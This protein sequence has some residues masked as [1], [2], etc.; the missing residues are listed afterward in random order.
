MKQDRAARVRA[1]TARPVVLATDSADPSGVGHHMIALAAHLGPGWNP[2]LAFAAGPAAAGFL[3]RARASGLAAVDVPPDGWQGLLA[4]RPGVLHVHAGIGWEGSGPVAA[5]RAAGWTVVRTEHLPWLITEP[6]ERQAYAAML[7]RVDALIAVSSSA[8][9]SWEAGLARMSHG[10]PVSVIANGIA[11]LPARVGRRKTRMA[12]GLT[13]AMPLILNIGRFTPQKGHATLVAAFAAVVAAHPAARLMMVGSGATRTAMA[14]AVARDGLAGASFHDARDDVPDLMAAA[15]LLVL[16]SLFEGLPLVLLEAMAAGLPVVASRTGGITDALGHDYPYLVPPGA[17]GDLARAIIGRLDDPRG[18]RAT[19]LRQ[20]ARF[21][22]GF[23]AARMAV[24]TEAVYARARTAG[25]PERRVTAMKAVTDVGFIG[26]GGIAERHLGVLARMPDVRVVAV[27]DTD[28]AR[29]ADAAARHGAQAFDSAEAMIAG[30][31]LDAL[32]ICVPPFAHGPAER[33][34]LAAGLP[35]F[36]EKPITRDLGLA[37]ELAAEVAAAGIVTAVGYH[38]R[39]LDTVDRARRALRGRPPQLIVG[40]W[41]DSTPPP[42][43]WGREAQSGGQ[44]VEQVTHLIDTARFLAGGVD[45]VHAFGNHLPRRAWPEVDVATASVATLRFESGTVATF[46]ATCLLEWNHRSGLHLFAEGLAI[47]LSDR[48]VMI[49]VGAGRH[50]VAA[51]GDPVWREDRDFIDAV[52]GGVNR[53]R[54]GYADALETHRI[55][56][57]MTESIRSGEVVRLTPVAAVPLPPDAMLRIEPAARDQHRR[58]R[59]LGVEAP[60]RAGF[61]DYDE[62]PAGPGQVRLDTRF[63][64]LSAGTELTFFK[65]TNPYLSASWDADAGV[66]REGEAA[67]RFPVPF[68]GYMEVGRVIDAQAE[69]FRVGDLVAGSWAHKTGHTADA[70]RDLLVPLPEALD[71][72]LGVF[73]AQMGPIAANAILYADALAHGQVPV[74]FGAG[75][76]GRRVLVWGGGTVGLMT[77]LFARAAGAAEIVLAEPSAFRRQAAAR[78]GLAAEPEE[79]AWQRAKGWGAPGARGADIVFQTRAHAGSLHLALRALRPQGTVIDLAFYQ[80]GMADLRLGE[81]FHHNGLGLIVAQIGRVPAGLAEAWTRAR[82]S[83]QTLAL[84]A[85]EGPAIRD[86]MITH[87]V[88][89]DEGPAFLEHLVADRPEFLQI[90]FEVPT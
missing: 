14:E 3:R 2:L 6:G 23:T 17:A 30:A 58:I 41:L 69:G 79:A 61:F 45:S 8:G 36:V 20:R 66:F 72:V 84:L 21:E 27:A 47:E 10:L 53:I 5:G 63:T 38:W 55:A 57:A 51:D 67:M 83:A 82:L 86:A 26:A 40:H 13:D 74:A 16:P 73:V 89:F 19:A 81:E 60:G 68:L 76:A 59:S 9:R 43:W 18:A 85:T 39:Y 37:E 46:S 1:E 15:D 48:E 35:F 32:Y 62:G 75:V 50:P 28:G 44:M 7:R 12:L 29:A 77:A 90:V 33:A 34:A 4:G 54:T 11:P 25:A 88:P 71:P 70:G 52:R 56:L 65:N 49:D 22:T 78:L 87:V 64:G 80:G 31:G 24:A 42:G